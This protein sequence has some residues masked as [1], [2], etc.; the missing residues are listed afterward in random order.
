MYILIAFLAP[1]LHAL[2]CI[3]DSHFSNHIFKKTSSL[4][5]YATISN[6]VLIPFLFLFGIPSIPPIDILLILFFIAFVEV[7]YQIPYYLALR[8][9]DTS[10]VVALFSLGKVAVPVLAYFIVDEKLSISQYIGFGLIILSGFALNF[11]LKKLHLNIAFFL[12]L[13]VSLALSLSSVLSKYSLG[14][15][16]FVTVL[17]WI[18]LF[19]TLITLTFLIP[20]HSR[21]DIIHSFP[22]YKKRFKFFIFNEFLT[23]GGSLAT[24][25]A[26]VH[27]PILMTKSIS[28]S[29]SIFT[30]IEGFLLYKFLGNRFKENFN[31]ND[32]I[33][34]II[35]FTTII[36]GIFMVL[37]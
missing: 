30:L 20:S 32:I 27:L 31:K 23:Q 19:A 24:T 8:N 15:V 16:N 34:K 2:S 17:F 35:S 25:I 28:S 5:F 6:I 14:Q 22:A 12:M 7:F 10:I 26:L 1:I 9:I 21:N 36:I 4:V 37:K 11:N 3:I 18:S 33:K 13:V 29:Q